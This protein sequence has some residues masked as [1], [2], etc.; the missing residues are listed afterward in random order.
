LQGLAILYSQKGDYE[1]AMV[2]LKKIL[3]IRPEDAGAYYN[4]ACMHSL[5]NDVEESIAWLK[6]AREKGF[7]NWD[8]LKKDKDL[9]NVRG[10]LF[11]K[12][13]IEGK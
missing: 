9:E 1:R 4:I 10:T 6:K 12:E 8:L 11:Y 5:Q 13:L 2:C 3:K 7:K